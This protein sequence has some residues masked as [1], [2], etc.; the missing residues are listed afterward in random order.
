MQFKKGKKKRKLRKVEKVR[1]DDL[2]A[3]G[4]DVDSSRDHGTRDSRRSEFSLVYMYSPSHDRCK[5]VYREA[6]GDCY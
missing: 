6:M 5:I 4:P 1:A 2:L 3:L